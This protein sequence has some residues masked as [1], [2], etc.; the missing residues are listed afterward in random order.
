MLSEPM[1]A[2]E[3]LDDCVR[4]AVVPRWLNGGGALQSV[5]SKGYRASWIHRMP[6]V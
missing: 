6:S 2:L 1:M 4:L 5:C 3:F